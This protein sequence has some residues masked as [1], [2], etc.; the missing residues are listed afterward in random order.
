MK[1]DK[2]KVSLKQIVAFEKSLR[3]LIEKG[4]QEVNL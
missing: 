3:L 4:I 1:K 2:E